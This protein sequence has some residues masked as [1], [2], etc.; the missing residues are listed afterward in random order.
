VAVFTTIAAI[1]S[2]AACVGMGF[3]DGTDGSLEPQ[4][5]A[6]TGFSPMPRPSGASSRLWRQSRAADRRGCGCARA[7]GPLAPTGRSA[8]P[9]GA[10]GLAATAASEAPALK[11]CARLFS[12]S[13]SRPC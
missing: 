4:H 7:Q 12:D 1:S 6:T 9:G 11:G 3:R 10:G 8:S 13:P 5:P 2:S